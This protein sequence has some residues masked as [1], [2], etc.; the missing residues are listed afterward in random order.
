ME[1][2]NSSSNTP[3]EHPTVDPN[4]L[5]DKFA[6]TSPNV[7]A[8]V[9]D[10]DTSPAATAA[11]E[12]FTSPSVAEEV[13]ISERRTAYG[14]ATTENLRTSGIWRILLP[15]VVILG[16]LAM[17][18]I[19]LFFLIPLFANSLNP[20]GAANLKH[21]SLTW[22]WILLILIDLG[23]AIIFTRGFLKIF[24]TQAGNYHS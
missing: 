20:D 1:Q 24:L 9:P 7:E 15:G 23:I 19:P 16:C 21:I 22:L 13:P 5:E 17:L 3:S 2:I 14:T 12:S 8:E 6:A 10:L 18:A 4:P 11:K